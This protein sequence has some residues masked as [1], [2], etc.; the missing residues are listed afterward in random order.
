[1]LMTIK[2]PI[3]TDNRILWDSLE[4]V[5]QNLRELYPVPMKAAQVEEK[6]YNNK[7][8]QT[9]RISS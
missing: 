4:N 7:I 5:D 1:M 9:F 3:M 2:H 8:K 6:N